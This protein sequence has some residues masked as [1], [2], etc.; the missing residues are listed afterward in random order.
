MVEPHSTVLFLPA[1][2]TFAVIH[3]AAAP[4]VLIRLVFTRARADERGVV[5]E[6]LV[7]ALHG[8]SVPPTSRQATLVEPMTDRVHPGDCPVTLPYGHPPGSPGC[9][10]PRGSIDTMNRYGVGV[11]GD[12]L[13]ILWPPS[14]LEFDSALVFAAWIVTLAERLDGPSFDEVQK[15]VRST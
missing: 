2:F 11:R 13:V 5:L 9:V 15:A 4:S 1:G 6:G 3:I 12:R 8:H 7:V 10:A 14:E